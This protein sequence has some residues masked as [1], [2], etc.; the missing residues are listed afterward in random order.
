MY[1]EKIEKIGNY[2]MNM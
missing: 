1:Q 2:S